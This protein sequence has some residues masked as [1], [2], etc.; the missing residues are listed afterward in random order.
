MGGVVW[1]NVV[2]FVN[3]HAKLIFNFARVYEEERNEA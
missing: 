2:M 1:K 3:L